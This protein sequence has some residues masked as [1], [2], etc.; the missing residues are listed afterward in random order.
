MPISVAALV[1]GRATITVDGLGD[2][3]TDVLTLT[4]DPN[5]FTAELEE[6]MNE[7]SQDG[8]AIRSLAMLL[9]DLIVSWDVIDAEGQPV[10]PSAD[11]LGRLGVPVLRRITEAIG[12]HENPN[13]SSATSGNGSRPTVRSVDARTG[14][15]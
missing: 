8:A 12:E 4:Y 6:R 11:F 1:V 3:G 2:E 10:A 5:K 15:R 13:S 7:L 9:A 14:T